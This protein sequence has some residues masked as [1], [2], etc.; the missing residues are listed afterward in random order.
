MLDVISQTQ[1]QISKDVFRTNPLV[2]LGTPVYVLIITLHNGHQEVTTFSTKELCL[3][4]LDT[5]SYEVDSYDIIQTILDQY[6]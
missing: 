5:I 3:K 6:I 2:T 1:T 4:Y